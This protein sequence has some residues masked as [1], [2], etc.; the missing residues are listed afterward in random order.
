MKLPIAILAAVLAVGPV[1]GAG[2]V[3]GKYEPSILHVRVTRQSHDFIRPWQKASPQQASGQGVVIGPDRILVPGNLLANATLVE[4]ERIGDG[5]RCEATVVCADYVANLGLVRP[6]DA[7]F[8]KTLRPVKI[9]PRARR[10]DRVTA[11]QFEPNGIPSISDGEIKTAE[12]TTPAGAAGRFL[13]YQVSIDLKLDS[14][15]NVPFFQRGRLIGF[16]VAYDKSGRTA[17]LIPSPVIEHFLADLADGEY[18]GF[19]EMGFGTSAI[20]DPQ[21]RR[22][23]GMANGEPGVYVEQVIPGSPAEKAGMRKGDVLVKL[24]AYAVNR[25][26]Q[27][28]DPEYGA[29]A[30]SHLIKTRR[31]VGDT[32]RCTVR[33]GAETVELEATLAH[34]AADDYPVPPYVLD[35]P[36]RFAIVGGFV[37]QELSRQLLA[38]W[39]ND[40][41][42]KAPRHLTRLDREQWERLQPGDKVVI[43]ARVLPT[44]ENIGFENLAFQIVA[45]V[46][47]K[48]VKSVR[49][50]A[51]AVANAGPVRFHT[52]QFD[53]PAVPDLTIPA[54]TLEL[55]DRFVR[56]RYGISRLSHLD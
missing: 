36:P 12:V 15:G 55:A 53:M 41:P 27:Y 4:V 50:L 56:E 19:P 33:R 44:P 17:T 35:R 21:V 45:S 7:E 32:L 6:K 16:M 11:V 22:Y 42:S 49:E 43:L 28:E 1:L 47:G 46:N 18:R 25:H 5:T 30:L 31:Q 54:A 34:L 9:R 26:G 39:G 8:A 13:V 10:G 14:T 40:W 2:P 29:M 24:D 52:V 37:F 51:E 48:P 38:V 23:L 3:G 20:R